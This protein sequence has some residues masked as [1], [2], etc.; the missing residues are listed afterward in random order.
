MTKAEINQKVA[1]MI[2]AYQKARP[3]AGTMEDRILAR[4]KGKSI[5]WS[6]PKNWHRKVDERL[7]D[8]FTSL[9]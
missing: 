2:E 3:G 8:V 9:V 6:L 1:E 4:E 7:L 5:F